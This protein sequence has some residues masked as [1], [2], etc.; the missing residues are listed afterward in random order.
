MM[1]QN[2]QG[3]F[4]P[5]AQTSKLE[6]PPNYDS[7]LNQIGR[8]KEDQ[9]AQ[10]FTDDILTK[11]L[12]GD[13]NKSTLLDDPDTVDFLPLSDAN[14]NTE[15]LI[16]EEIIDHQDSTI[17]DK[18]NQKVTEAPKKSKHLRKRKVKFQEKSGDSEYQTNLKIDIDSSSDEEPSVSNNSVAQ[19]KK[20]P[21][22]NK[23][24]LNDLI[25]SLNMTDKSEQTFKI[26]PKMQAVIAKEFLSL[27]KDP[28]TRLFHTF[29]RTKR[30]WEMFLNWKGKRCRK[31]IKTFSW[32]PS[33]VE[34]KIIQL[35][36][37][38]HV[39][40]IYIVIDFIFLQP[41]G[42]WQMIKWI[43]VFHVGESE[44]EINRK[45]KRNFVLSVINKHESRAIRDAY[46]AQKERREKRERRT[47]KINEF[48]E[49]C[50]AEEV[51]LQG[52]KKSE[53]KVEEKTEQPLKRTMKVR[54]RAGIFTKLRVISGMVLEIIKPWPTK[55]GEKHGEK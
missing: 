5:S 20:N 37:L 13:G 49:T 4:I 48:E 29:M 12:S 21:N 33:L 46:Q 43:W 23:F 47:N 25:Q 3:D 36:A 22:P 19:K 32:L 6:L 54:E 55:L 44:K 42:P 8:A 10:Q 53:E 9:L 30:D 31:G 27:E 41:W 50:G 18:S 7:V 11:M 24:N 16:D 45:R 34:L 1:D 38:M 52:G 51:R 35:L 40:M 26:D 14:I 2:G 17:F 15:T 39:I 28:E